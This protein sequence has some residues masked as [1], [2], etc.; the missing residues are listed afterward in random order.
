M[1]MKNNK[2]SNQI[3]DLYVQVWRNPIYYGKLLDILGAKDWHTLT[4]LAMFMDAEGECYP[5][6][7]TLGQI[8]GLKNIAT[9]SRRIGSLE[10]KKFEGHPVLTVVRSRAKNEKGIW[11]FTNNRYKIN[12]LIITIFV[13]HSTTLS[14]RK[15]QA[16]ELLKQRE[17]LA[18]SFTF[19][20]K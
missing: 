13:A 15:Q 14:K 11:Q 1:T 4:A 16:E 6:E 10:K 8:L 3:E 19:F 5:K 12:P 18:K 7:E 17:K 9:I 2:P 20:A